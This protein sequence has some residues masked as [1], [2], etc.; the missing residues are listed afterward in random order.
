MGTPTACSRTVTITITITACTAEVTRTPA[1]ASTRTLTT[2]TRDVHPRR[3]AAPVAPAGEPGA[4]AR[5]LR[6]L[7]RAGVCRAGG[8]GDGRDQRG[9]LD[10]R[11]RGRVR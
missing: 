9:G 6:L 10:R 5:G 7:A 3:R 2:S 4:A 1:R 11:G 8:L